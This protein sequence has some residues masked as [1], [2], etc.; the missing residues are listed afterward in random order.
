ME[1][2]PQTNGFIGLTK[3]RM[4]S[5][6]DGIFAFAMTLLVV[7]LNVPDKAAQ[8]QS[9]EF[10]LHTI[11]SLRGD[12]LHYV[13]A[14]M[15]LAGFWLSHTIQYHHIRVVDRRFIWINL[16]ALLF[17]ALLPFTTS[18]SGDFSDIPLAAI[19]FEANLLVIGLVFTFQ[20]QYATA[21]HRL[22][23]PDLDSGYV[24]ESLRRGLVIPAVSLLA[25]LLALAGFTSSTAIYLL[26]PFI[27]MIVR[28]AS[29]GIKSR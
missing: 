7:G 24:Q 25:I 29:A 28:G 8:I 9:N 17:V 6:T 22:T 2:E 1:H 3:N 4:E 13:I 11:L 10:V 26:L 5:L 12:F 23:G 14:F 18:L 20:W 27:F 19:V 21:D 15:I 16:I